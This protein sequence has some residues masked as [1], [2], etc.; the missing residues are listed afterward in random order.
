MS[1]Y[2]GAQQP[3]SKSITAQGAQQPQVHGNDEIVT[4]SVMVGG[5]MSEGVAAKASKSSEGVG[6]GD[7][8]ATHEKVS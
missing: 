8:A 5:P 7:T 2:S 6:V 1:V 4:T 3:Q